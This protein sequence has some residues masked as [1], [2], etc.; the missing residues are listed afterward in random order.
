MLQKKTG[1]RR[2]LERNYTVHAHISYC[3]SDSVVPGWV[4]SDSL[5]IVFL[6]IILKLPTV[7]VY[8]SSFYFYTCQVEHAV[9]GDITLNF[10]GP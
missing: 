4:E 10:G 6:S 3:I 9:L 5:R 2:D 7:L 1:R 8:L